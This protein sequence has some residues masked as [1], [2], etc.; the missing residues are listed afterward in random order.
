MLSSSAWRL[1]GKRWRPNWISSSPSTKRS[2]RSRSLLRPSWRR[3]FSLPSSSS[4]L[5]LSPSSLSCSASCP[6]LQDHGIACEPGVEIRLR[7]EAGTATL[8]A[9]GCADRR[10]AGIRCGAA[11]ALRAAG[12]GSPGTQRSPL[13]GP[14]ARMRTPQIHRS[15]RRGSSSCRVSQP[16]R[17]HKT[18]ETPRSPERSPEPE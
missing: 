1:T 16:A 14:S 4:A 9:R 17:H 10:P 8:H 5:T 7:L 13:S 6:D 2:R 12:G 11:A 3:L 15:G 18:P